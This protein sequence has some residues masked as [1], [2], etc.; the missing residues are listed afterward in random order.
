MT[1]I[2]VIE[3]NPINRDVL[4]RRFDKAG[5]YRSVCGRRTQWHHC[6]SNATAGSYID[7]YRPWRNG[8]LRSD[9]TLKA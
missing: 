4:G 5:I 7:G 2:L 3:D 1:T 6:Y 9:K 8:R